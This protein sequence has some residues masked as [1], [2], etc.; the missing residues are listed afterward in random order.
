MACDRGDGHYELAG[1]YS[2]DTQCS[3]PAPGVLATTDAEWIQQVSIYCSIFFFGNLTNSGTI[4]ILISLNFLV[5]K[6]F[7][8]SFFLVNI[9][10]IK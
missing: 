6:K 2:W 5:K 1:S 3:A 4:L 8:F 7:Y 10:S 9:K